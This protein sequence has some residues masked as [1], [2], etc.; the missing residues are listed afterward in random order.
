M[1]VRGRWAVAISVLAA[2]TA[3]ALLFWP[4]RASVG[5]RTNLAALYRDLGRAFGAGIGPPETLAPVHNAELRAHAS[6]V[7]YLSET[8][9]EPDG[10][11][12]WATL[13]AEAAQVRFA[14]ETLQRH[15]SL[16]RFDQC[17]PTRT[18]L[19]AG[20]EEVSGALTATA[21]RLESPKA[22]AVAGADVPAISR[23][24]RDPIC[25]CLAHHAHEGGADGP[26]AAGLDAAFVRD[27][28]LEVAVIADHALE[29]APTVPNG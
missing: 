14:I 24:T 11:R 3:L 9:R 26:L 8:A 6:Y 23:A 12:R 25:T 19:R 5:L 4:R 18:A 29:T 13:L 28:L 20:V 7:Q 15:R 27:L 10:R 2:V 1:T 22:P 17:G 16:D 21:T